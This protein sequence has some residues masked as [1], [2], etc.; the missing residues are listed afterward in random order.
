MTQARLD[1]EQRVNLIMDIRA[2]ERVPIERFKE[3]D[4][5][6]TGNH[7]LLLEMSVAEVLA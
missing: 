5:M 2:M 7:G 3:F 6:T 4:R 1:H